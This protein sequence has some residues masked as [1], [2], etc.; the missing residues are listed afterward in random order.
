L[1][2]SFADLAK[3]KS[4]GGLARA[5]LNLGRVNGSNGFAFSM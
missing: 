5:A 2:H 3:V 4:Q 1:Y